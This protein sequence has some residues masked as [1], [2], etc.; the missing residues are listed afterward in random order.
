MALRDGSWQVRLELDDGTTL[1]ASTDDLTLAQLDVAERA[2]G[3]PWPIMDPRRSARVAMAL[4]AVLL[5]RNGTAEDKALALAAEF[6][7]SKLH[8]A[9]TYVPPE[10]PLPPVEGPHPD[11]A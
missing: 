6:P 5:I 9:F 10:D 11:P 1:E 7:A 2:S 3:I 4:F 8:G